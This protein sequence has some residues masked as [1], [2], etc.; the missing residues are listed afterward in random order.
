MKPLLLLAICISLTWACA[1][2]SQQ[3]K[4]IK[5][6]T[7]PWPGN[8]FLHLA[9]ELGYFKAAGLNVELLQLTSLSDS[10]DAYIQGHADGIASSLVEVV[11]APHLGGQPLS[12]VLF[13]D[14]SNGGDVIL[15]RNNDVSISDLKGKRIGVEIASLGIYVLARAL[16][17]YGMT[18][19]DVELVNLSQETGL[20]AMQVGEL[21]ALVTYPPFSTR[22]L[23][24]PGIHQVFNTTEIPYEILDTVAVSTHTLERNPDLIDKFRLVWQQA[25][26]YSRAH[27][28]HSYQLMA[29]RLQLS[30]EEFIQALQGIEILSAH[31]QANLFSQQQ[32]I[33]RLTRQVCDLLVET[34]NISSSCLDSKPLFDAPN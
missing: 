24:Q 1:E 33:N 11:L 28:N 30:Q 18:I 34:D 23:R 21:D 16:N 26:D 9:N 10:Q 32:K 13:P 3:S 31:E 14:Y 4:P 29:D 27:P 7:S 22:L 25:L 12:V 19:K 5:I 20:K 2:S 8:E 17:K 6:A 15:T